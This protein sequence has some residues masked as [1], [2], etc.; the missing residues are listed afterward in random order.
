ME[1]NTLYQAD[2]ERLLSQLSYEQDVR[3][4]PDNLRRARFKTGW[5]DASVRNGTYTAQTL[6][7]LTWQNLGYRFGREFGEQSSE[8]IEKA[9]RFLARLHKED[10]GLRSPSAQQYEDAFRSLDLSETHRDMLKIHFHAPER[11][12]TATQMANAIGYPRYGAANMHYGRLGR[13]VGESME[14]D[15]LEERLGTLVTFEKRYGEWHWIMRYQV[16][17]AL[18]NLDWVGVSEAALPE[19][20]PE[21]API[22]EGARRRV[23]VNA[24]ER[25][26]RARRRCVEHHGASCCICGFDF[27]KVYGEVAEGY[28]HVHHLISVAKIGEVYEVDPVNDLRPV[29]PNC[30]AVIHRR[31]PAYS[32][33]EVRAFLGK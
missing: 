15:P 20:I 17:R 19:E 5:K 18:E 2:Y 27:D 3:N 6:G 7:E 10:K 24:Y 14:F 21:D 33:E 9:Y 16:A 31:D 22:S 25:S 1:E 4:P 23:Y 26:P 11:T 13:L 30:H 29:C 12:I 8:E 28:I 32:I